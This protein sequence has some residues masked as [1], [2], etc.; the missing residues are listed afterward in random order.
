MIFKYF[1]SVYLRFFL[2][3]LISLSLSSLVFLSE[4]ALLFYSYFYLSPVF[5]LASVLLLLFLIASRPTLFTLDLFGGMPL[6]FS[7]N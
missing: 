3:Y 6:P 4:V 2:F 7:S 5:Y 1:L